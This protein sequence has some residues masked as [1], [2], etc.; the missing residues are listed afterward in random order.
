MHIEY[1]VHEGTVKTRSYN[2][3]YKIVGEDSGLS[4]VLC[5][6]GGPGIPH[7]YL[8]PLSQLAASRRV[9][10]YDQLG[11]GK[12]DKIDEPS[13]WTV[14]LFLEE[15]DGV[16]NALEL[17]EF[18]L[19]GQSWGGMLALEYMLRRPSGVRSL[20]LANSPASMP[21]WALET[22]KLR[23]QLPESV[24]NVLD[25][26]E[27]AGSTDSEAYAEA[28]MEFYKLHLCRLHPWPDYVTRAFAKQAEA[29]QVYQ[30]MVGPNEFHIVGTLKDWDVEDR[31]S[32]IHIPTL[33]IS[34]RYDEA[35][36]AISAVI[37]EGIKGSE[38][39]LFEESSHMPHV[40][41]QERFMDALG[42]WLMR[43]D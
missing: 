40:E 43:F 17:D 39:L 20:I 42:N 30:T 29:P 25:L 19:F 8:E 15:L 32:E 33:I 11:V 24:R 12:S 35:T 41:E 1:P 7:D 26:H 13:L 27:A 18:H 10:F 34:G 2:T 37:H 36:P 38:W 28:T 31:L 22:G 5:L 16:R 23:A 6:H 21:R 3:W 14:E 4:P 9:I